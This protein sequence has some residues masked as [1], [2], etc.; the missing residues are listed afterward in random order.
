MILKIAS[1]TISDV[2]ISTRS[3]GVNWL[4]TND[5]WG[6]RAVF[7]ETPRALYYNFICEQPHMR[8]SSSLRP[9]VN[10][11]VFFSGE[12]CCYREMNKTFKC[13]TQWRSG[14]AFWKKGDYSTWR[15]WW[16]WTLTALAPPFTDHCPH[17]HHHRWSH[18]S[19]IIS[20]KFS[21]R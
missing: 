8:R 21:R 20:Q 12:H 13:S 10:L 9:W 11:L 16:W 5:Y 17:K 6:S 18:F 4:V 3:W 14:S 19:T 15:L 1:S 7:Y 2:V